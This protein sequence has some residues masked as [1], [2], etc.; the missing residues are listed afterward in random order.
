M[1]KITLLFTLLFLGGF[2]Y[3]QN[4]SSF[5]STNT[6]GGVIIGSPAG[7]ASAD[8]PEG[9]DIVITHSAT[10][11]IVPGDGITCNN[12]GIANDNLYYRVF[13]LENDF[14]IDGIFTVTSAEVGIE[15]LISSTGTFTLTANIYTTDA[16]FPTGTLTLLGTGMLDAVDADAGTVVSI[17]VDAVVPVGAIMVYELSITGDGV[18]QFFV[19][20]NQDG[21]TGV[22][23]IQATDCGADVPTDLNDFGFPN[24][25]VMNVVGNTGPPPLNDDPD[26]AT[27]LTVGSVF[28]DFPLIA[29]NTEATATAID[30]PSCG[31][32][33]EADVW[34]SAVV[35]PSGSITFESQTDDGSITDTAISVYEGEIGALVEVECN[36]DDGAGL[37]SLVALEGRTAGEVLYLRAWEWNGGTL[38]TFQ[39]S[40]YS[41]C[42]VDAAA[43]EITGTGATEV[44]ICVGED[45]T[46]FIDVSIVGTGV[47]TNSG[48]IITNDTGNILDLPAGPPFD[49]EAFDPG[50]CSIWYIRYEDGLTGLEV[51]ANVEGLVGC[52]D[53]SNPIVV[54][55]TE[56]G[57]VCP[58]TNDICENAFALEC[59]T[60]VVGSTL[61]ATDSG[62]NAAPDVFY[63]YTGSGI[64]ENI[65]LSLCD[66]ATDY[67]S[68]LRVFDDECNLINEIAV[69][70]DSCGLQSELTFLSDGTTTYTIMVEGFGTS[71]G[72]FSMAVSCEELASCLPVEDLVSANITDTSA[73]LSWT[74]I[75]NP[76]AMSYDLEWGLQGF[77]V[78]TGTVEAGLTTPDFPLTGLAANTAYDF[79]VTAICT[80]DDSSEITGPATFTTEPENAPPGECTWTLEMFDS[81]P[82][83]WNGATLSVFR[84]GLVVLNN[85]ALDDAPGNDG[86]VGIL[87]FDVIPGEDITTVLTEPG[88][89]PEEISYNIINAGGVTVVGSG[90]AD[91]DIPSGTI[92]ADCVLSIDDN[93]LEGFTFFP[94]PAENVLNI[95]AQREVQSI[96]V[97]N[98]VGQKVM[99]QSINA[100][101]S[102]IDISR[103]SNGAY[104]LQVSANDQVGTFKLIKQ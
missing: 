84:D 56:E 59:D 23:W 83:G 46:D 104:I 70:D 74:D 61:L 29:D 6:S 54:T 13:D 28:E 22:S 88:A 79:Y 41:D 85:V 25:Y 12:G 24:S 35:P 80:A 39:V 27:E 42:P 44:T 3:G 5:L 17:P 34:Y 57:D 43:I 64:N 86:A 98:L 15:T 75:N 90:D 45:I 66:G 100:T 95:S 10:Q 4:S 62:S 82:D 53:L 67:D 26:T 76:A 77:A 9:G 99:E 2:I 50:M 55:K 72:N 52:F 1:K 96:A 92:T 60:T 71:A 32:F 38:G 68:L 65:T 94:N 16:P 69:N 91:N 93:A 31:L 49:L 97:F 58:P 81:F 73:D 48:W 103:L 63:T 11:N 51:D 101:S 7:T 87:T 20:A 33:T 89:F 36:D 18:T 14:A 47:G 19:G 21:Q 8:T 37:F 40:A 30:D 78:G 102:A